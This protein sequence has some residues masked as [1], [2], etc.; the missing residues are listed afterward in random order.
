MFNIFD[1]SAIVI[2][3]LIGFFG[4][5]VGVLMSLFYFIAG[6]GG[7]WVAQSYSHVLGINYY[8][9][10][11]IAALLFLGIGSIIKKVASALLLGWVDRFLGFLMGAVIGLWLVIS[12]L[13]PYA[14]NMDK[15]VRVTT[16]GSYFSQKVLPWLS[17]K[18][19][20]IQRYKIADFKDAFPS[21][22]ET[23][24]KRN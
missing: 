3:F 23:L 13:Y 24:K 15:D 10:F 6:F 11:I 19:P 20:T 4:F 5:N 14:L 7:A 9:V 16:N 8:I 1:G 21:V 17:N 22:K 12:V 2:I 18:I